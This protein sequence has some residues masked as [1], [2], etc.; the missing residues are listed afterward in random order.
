[1]P[2]GSSPGFRQSWRWVNTSTR[3][4][5]TCYPII[6]THQSSVDFFSHMEQSLNI[7]RQPPLA[8]RPTFYFEYH[9]I[10][11]K[12]L[13]MTISSFL[14]CSPASSFKIWC[15]PWGNTLGTETDWSLRPCV[16]KIIR[17]SKNETKTWQDVVTYERKWQKGD[18]KPGLPLILKRSVDQVWSRLISGTLWDWWEAIRNLLCRLTILLWLQL[19]LTYRD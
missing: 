9:L 18:S 10:P 11:S 17:F 19:V 5:K 7:W 1:M 14:S 16:Q 4:T 3:W 12:S 8:T 2:Q 15:V 13:Q 6:F